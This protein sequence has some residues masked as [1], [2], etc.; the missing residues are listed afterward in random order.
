MSPEDTAT[1]APA[2]NLTRLGTLVELYAHVRDGGRL[3][4][5]SRNGWTLASPID[6]LPAL[7][8]DLTL[9]RK[10]VTPRSVWV[11]PNDMPTP[12]RPTPQ[13]FIYSKSFA[14]EGAIEF[15]EVLK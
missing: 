1:E 14:P 11:V 12:A 4:V 6:H 8:D 7:E 3:E 5:R 10:Y 9:W 13:V 15:V 2:P